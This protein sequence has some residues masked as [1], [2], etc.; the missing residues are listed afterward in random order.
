[1]VS[2]LRSFFSFYSF[3]PFWYSSLVNVTAEEFQAKRNTLVP[4]FRNDAD[5]SGNDGWVK[6]VLR[7]SFGVT[8]SF[9]NLVYHGGFLPV[10]FPFHALITVLDAV[11][12]HIHFRGQRLTALCDN[13]GYLLDFEQ[14]DL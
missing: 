9:K 1:M 2:A 14:I 6:K 10:G 12:L 4:C 7:M 5:K 8:I 11:A 13:G 3:F